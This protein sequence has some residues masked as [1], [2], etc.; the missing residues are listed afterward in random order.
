[1]KGASNIDNGITIDLKDL[2]TIQ[3]S[4]DKKIVALGS[5]LKWGDV[6][7]ELAKHGIQVNGARGSDVGVGGFTTGGG[8]SYF[9]N[10]YG[11]G[12]DNVANYEVV[13]ASGQILNVNRTSYPDLYKALRG[14]GP[15]FGIVTRFDLE[16]FPQ[17]DI[18][19]GSLI[20][21]YSER[22]SVIPAFSKFAYSTDTKVHTWMF[23][24]NLSGQK[25]FSVLN[26]YSSP[27]VDP[28]VFAE[29]RS[30]PHLSSD[31]AIRS[32]VN[33]TDQI[34]AQG[35]AGSR[36]MFWTHTFKMDED[37]I[38]WFVDMFYAE[39]D[40]IKGKYDGLNALPLIQFLTR[41]NLARWARN[42][43]NALP[44][45]AAGGPY[46]NII[47]ALMW[48]NEADDDVLIATISR[49]MNKAKEEGIRRGIFEEYVYMNYGSEY[50]DVLESYGDANKAALKGVAKKYDPKGVFQKLRPGYFT[51]RGAPRVEGPGT[52]S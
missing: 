24:L 16:A 26:M 40:A 31:T 34:A 51:F 50:Q 11:W 44:L 22:A 36:D 42:G 39:T 52:G 33:M 9:A 10:K 37:F 48:K 13:T 5:G 3:P 38:A 7:T 49:V 32:L 45:R 25:V 21:P 47:F 20:Y 35:P 23:V 4:Q 12:C 6:Y 1:M 18:F 43:G 29:M 46:I 28:P 14:G 27:I 41:T 8:I 19:S 2:N 30:I 15:N 17:G